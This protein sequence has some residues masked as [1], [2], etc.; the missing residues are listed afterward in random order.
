MSKQQPTPEDIPP[1]AATVTRTPR[2][3][4]VVIWTK[5]SCQQCRMVKFRLEAAGVPYVEADLTAREHAHDLEYFR[6]LGYLSAP[7]TEYRAIAVAGFMPSE[8]DRVVA[9]WRAD[10]SNAVSA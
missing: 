3:G 9:A 5:P 10:N 8:I 6:G 2:E 4:D 7:V 1:T